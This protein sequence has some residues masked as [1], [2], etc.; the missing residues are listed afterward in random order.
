MQQP[1]A[2]GD[3]LVSNNPNPPRV[4]W[5]FSPFVAL[6][7]PKSLKLSIKRSNLNSRCVIF[8]MEFVLWLIM[9]KRSC[10]L[11]FVLSRT[12]GALWKVH[13]IL[14]ESIIIVIKLLQFNNWYVC[15]QMPWKNFKCSV[16][17]Y[18]A[19]FSLLS[20]SQYQIDELLLNW[21]G[22]FN[23]SQ[24]SDISKVNSPEDDATRKDREAIEQQE[25]NFFV[26]F[27]LDE[28]KKNTRTVQRKE[29]VSCRKK[30][31]NFACAKK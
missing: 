11:N 9:T 12:C 21:V 19:V 30:G 5:L 17:S 1:K 23:E 28:C 8:R 10:T 13:M 4:S 29:C 25:K 24:K 31:E 3:F 27:F 14:Y 2:L 22:E 6:I 15:F 7:G 16:S 18:L 26:S 20:V